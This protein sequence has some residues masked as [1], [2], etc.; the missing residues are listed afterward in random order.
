MLALTFVLLSCAPMPIPTSP[1]ETPAPAATAPTAE[2]PAPATVT[3]PTATLPTDLLQGGSIVMGAVGNMNLGVNAMH[4]FL[5]NAIYDSLLQPD[6][7][8]GALKPALAESYDV[9]S[10]AT[11][12]TFHLKRGVRWHNG[13]VFTADDVVGTINALSSPNFRGT[14]V[15]DFGPLIRASALDTQTVQV[16]LKD[17][18]CPALTYVGT[19]KIFPR[20]V[21]EST[22]FP[23]L[24]AAQ[25]IG[26]G[27][28]K[29]VSRTE[30][31]FVLA[32]NENYYRGAPPI[33]SWMLRVFPDAAALRAAFASKQIDVMAAEPG[34]YAAIK[35]VEGR[36]IV[37]ADAP[38]IVTLMFNLDDSRLNDGR[39]RQALTMALDRKVLL[40]D[41]GGQG[42]L[43]DA[44][45]LPGFWAY[46]NSIPG[47]PFDVAKAKQLLSD[48]GWR[49]SG[50]GVLRKNGKPLALQLWTEGDDPMLEP[51]AFRLREMYAAL[52]IQVELELDDRA[53]WITHAFQHRFDLLLFSRRLPL[54]LD[55]QWFWHSSQNEQG[56]GFNFGSYA[57]ARVD[58]L[59]K[60][61][62]RVSNCNAAGRA[63]LFGE[64]NKQLLADAP[65][66]FLLTPKKYLVARER[67]VGLA[68]SS[69]AGDFWNLEQWRVKP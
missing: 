2:A 33:D 3:A 40:D 34:D 63:A 51:L 30:D 46:P 68:P 22:N 19:L 23:R 50:D 47:Y 61:L 43:V 5:Q 21:V 35:K 42:R 37:S 59:M 29:F 16:S 12:F 31:Q 7:A 6:P 41:I 54:D 53:G 14:P 48:A 8:N 69:F 55:Q 56:N 36:N 1:A 57:N 49:N 15:T 13:D 38:E 67:V 9:S 32:R 24:T 20:A 39:V 26:T 58:T 28:L 4:P 66:A 52:G 60:D 25:L 18:Y 11:M 44:S 45:A 65:A 27:P 10:D 17:G 64:I 62:L